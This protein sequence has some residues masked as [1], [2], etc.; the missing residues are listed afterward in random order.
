[1][2]SAPIKIK[3]SAS[4]HLDENASGVFWSISTL[5]ARIASSSARATSRPLS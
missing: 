2:A 4:F 5:S 3:A 1:M